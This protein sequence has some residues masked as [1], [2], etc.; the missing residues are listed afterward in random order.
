MSLE[1]EEAAVAAKDMACCASCGKAE[2]DDVKLKKCACKLVK[3]CSVDCQK[4]HRPQHKKMCKKTLAELRD[5]D[6]FTLPDGSC[7]GECPI[8]CLP[9]SLDPAKTTISHCCSQLICNGCN[10]ANKKREI[11]AGFLEPRC[12]FCRDPAPKSR[13]EGD[14]RMMKRV[15]K[16]DPL[17]ICQ[18]GRRRRNEWDYETAFEYFAKAA[19]L[20]D[21]AAHFELACLC[22]NGC[23]VE[24]DE[25]KQV[26]H[27]EEAAIRGHPTARHNLGVREW[28]N[29]R[30]ERAKRHFIIAANLGCNDSLKGLR[31]LYAEGHAT[32]DNYLSALRAYQAALDATKSPERKVAEA[33]YAYAFND[34]FA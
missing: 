30:F 29:G 20:G 32:K 28:R 34:C 8:C 9:L 21:A 12:P 19:E 2:V 7:F 33:Y 17:A 5:D 16:N 15:K 1:A 24:K 4:N 22:H 25:K 26:Y 23:C 27:L 18:M 10:V 3:Y 11:E 6:L 14:K 31:M 13:E